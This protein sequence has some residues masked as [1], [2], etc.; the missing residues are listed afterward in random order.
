[1]GCC[2]PQGLWKGV[3]LGYHYDPWDPPSV[4][5]YN[6]LSYPRTR[7]REQKNLILKLNFLLVCRSFCHSFCRSFYRS[8]TAPFTAPFVAQFT[9]PF[10]YWEGKISTIFTI[11]LDLGIFK[12]ENQPER[13]KERADN[14]FDKTKNSLRWILNGFRPKKFQIS[15]IFTYRPETA[16]FH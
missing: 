15:T 6:S 7:V 12:R 3:T 5:Q 1:M 13:Q 4:P 8:F 9:S 11:T 2:G 14:F 10:T 16:L